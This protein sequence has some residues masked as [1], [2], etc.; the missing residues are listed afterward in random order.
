MGLPLL[1]VLILSV[2]TM[3]ISSMVISA[4]ILSLVFLLPILFLSAALSSALTITLPQS[5]LLSI[6]ILMPLYCPPLIVAQS[7]VM[8]AQMG[9]PFLSEIYLLCAMAIASC[10]A[11]P[12]LIVF[13][14]RK[15][16][17]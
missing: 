16:L 13:L 6:V 15:G 1:G 10:L 17:G 8:H 11:L 9:V 2:Y 12:W 4:V 3:P 7:M 5:S 14:L